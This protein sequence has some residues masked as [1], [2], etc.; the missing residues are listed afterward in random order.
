[1][2]AVAY[3]AGFAPPVDATAH[4][5]FERSARAVAEEAVGAAR[6][7]RPTVDAET[8]VVEGQPA[9]V[10]VEQ[11]AD[12]DLLVVGSRGLGGFG[13]LLLGS[14]GHAVVQHAA[15]PVVIVRE[16]PAA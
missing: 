15:C 4:E 7:S 2:P 6:T 10:L 16:K 9:S 14:V 11:A 5:A 12:A 8:A 1:M 3:A 13:S